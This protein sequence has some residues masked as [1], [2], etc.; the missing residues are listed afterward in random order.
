MEGAVHFTDV[1]C[2]TVLGSAFFCLVDTFPTSFLTFSFKRQ[3]C[4]VPFNR[5]FGYLCILL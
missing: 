3:S 1:H 4:R 5:A 2:G